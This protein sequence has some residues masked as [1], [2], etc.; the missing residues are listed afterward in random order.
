MLQASGAVIVGLLRI[1]R[2][3]N[4]NLVAPFL[5]RVAAEL[6]LLDARKERREVVEQRERFA[7]TLALQ[8]SLSAS[9]ECSR[10]RSTGN[11]WLR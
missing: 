4:D 5:E 9:I 8:Q 1:D 10:I 3:L 2:R 7:V 11:T 6:Q